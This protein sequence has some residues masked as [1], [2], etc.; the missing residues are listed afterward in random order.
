VKIWDL[1]IA[2]EVLS[3]QV[4]G[5]AGNVHWSPDGSHII[6]S[7]GTNTPVIRRVWQSTQALID[8]AYDCCVRRELTAEEREQ[9]GLPSLEE[10][11]AGP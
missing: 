3:F 1:E 2:A 5:G 9:F 4:V 10:L 11:K 8:Y 7:G 6:A